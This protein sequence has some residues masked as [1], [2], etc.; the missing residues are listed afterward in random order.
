MAY[1]LLLLFFIWG[2]ALAVYFLCWY[3]FGALKKESV[4]IHPAEYYNYRWAA[5]VTAGILYG[6]HFYTFAEMGVLQLVATLFSPV[7]FLGLHRFLDSDKWSDAFLFC[8]GFLGCWYTCAYYGLFLSVFVACFV[9]K[10]GYQKV[11]KLARKTLIRGAVTAGI[12]LTCLVPLI[13]GMQ[14]AKTEM[15]LSRPKV[16]VQFL[17]TVLSDYLRI[18]ENS[19]LYGNILGLGNPHRGIFLG[20]LLLCLAAMGAIAVFMARVPNKIVERGGIKPWIQQALFPQHYGFFYIFLAGSAFWLS[21]G[22]ALTPTNAAGLGVYRIVA[23]LSPYN[24]L[25]QFVP[26][27]SSIRSSYRFAIF[28]TLFLAVLAG[29]G[30]LWISRRVGKRWAPITL[31][32]LLTAVLFELW[33]LPPR[34]IKVPGSLEELPP[35]YQHVKKLPADAVLIELPLARG[36]SERHIEPQ[37]RAVYYSTFHWLKMTNGYSGFTPLSNVELNKVITESEAETILE[38]FK[39]FD[40]QYVLT[41]EDKLNENEEQKLQALE[42]DGLILLARE[43]TDQLYKINLDATEAENPLPDVASLTFYES[44]TLSNHVTLCLSYQVDENRCELTTPWKRRIEYDVT[45]YDTSKQEEPV[46]I[47]T[48]VYRNS[49]LLTQTFN[50]VEIDLSAPPPGEYKVRIQQRSGAATHTRRG[51]CRIY[52]SGFVSFESIL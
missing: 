45:W 51:V 11:L 44:R 22:M 2:A 1:N 15:E 47:S 25:Y 17:S 23:W 50:T 26:G 41:H 46:L 38:A 14:S 4:N 36:N 37:A 30:I 21:F 9:I 33:P 24:F 42:G 16:V 13:V 8:L 5:A 35:I 12:T 32:F 7:T 29:W 48:G 40:I 18:P 49:K 52:E 34:L 28:C 3:L 6:F 31:L 19:W 39:T 27:F 20:I 43:G 10:I